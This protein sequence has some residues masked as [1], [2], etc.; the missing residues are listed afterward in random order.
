M[1]RDRL[2]RVE[3]ARRRLRIGNPSDRN[4]LAEV[5]A[6]CLG[7]GRI[8][9]DLIRLAGIDHPPVD[10]LEGVLGEVESAGARLGGG[11]NR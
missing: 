5:I 7:T 3:V 10:D 4:L 9:H 2:V 8:D 6:E 11:G 1:N